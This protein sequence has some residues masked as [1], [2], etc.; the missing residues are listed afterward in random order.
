[1]KIDLKI[2]FQNRLFFKSL[3]RIDFV[4]SLFGFFKIHRILKNI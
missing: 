3:L 1:M 2:D 4:K